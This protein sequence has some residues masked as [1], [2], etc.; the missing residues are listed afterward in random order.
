MESYKDRV[1]RVLPKAELRFRQLGQV[2]Q[3][4]AYV[5]EGPLTGWCATEAEAWREAFQAI[6]NLT[7]PPL[8]E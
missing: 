6:S 3:C 8:Q 4:R 1:K 2:R 5:V 7:G